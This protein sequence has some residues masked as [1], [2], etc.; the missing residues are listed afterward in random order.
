MEERQRRMARKE[1][2]ERIKMI[3]KECTEDEDAVCYVTS[4]DADALYMAIKALEQE[5]MW[6]SCSDKL[7]EENEYVNNVCKY[8]LIQDEYGDMCVTRYTKKGWHPIESLFFL[9]DV[10]AWIPLPKEYKAEMESEE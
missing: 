3:L 2:A 9:D 7:P 5:P 1:S 8:Y 10:V 4:D 6:I